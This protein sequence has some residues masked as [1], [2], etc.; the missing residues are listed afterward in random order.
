MAL[1]YLFKYENV[2]YIVSYDLDFYLL[3][4]VLL[5]D[6]LFYFVRTIRMACYGVNE[7]ILNPN[8]N[9]VQPEGD[10]ETAAKL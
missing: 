4:T 2:N 9:L 8:I 6:V 3:G 7:G 10:V 5:V 1:Y